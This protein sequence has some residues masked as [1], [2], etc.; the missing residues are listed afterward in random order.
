MKRAF[1]TGISG[2][3]GSYGFLSDRGCGL[4]GII[5]GAGIFDTLIIGGPA[6]RGTV[7]RSF[8]QL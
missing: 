2:Q 5:R 8:Y 7:E 4:R 6:A 1:S 3:D